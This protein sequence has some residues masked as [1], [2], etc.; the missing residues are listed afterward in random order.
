MFVSSRVA[1]KEDQFLQRRFRVC[2]LLEVNEAEHRNKLFTY[3]GIGLGRMLFGS[4]SLTS[5]SP[6]Q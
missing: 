2:D 3:G 4:A 1:Q 5:L 6:L